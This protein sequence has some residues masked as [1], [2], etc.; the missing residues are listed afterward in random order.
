M[1]PA[2]YFELSRNYADLKKLTIFNF[3]LLIHT[4]FD[5]WFRYC[6]ISYLGE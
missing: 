2:S 1:C 6:N 5:K 4:V 3:L